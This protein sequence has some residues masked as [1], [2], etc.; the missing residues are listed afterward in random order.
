MNSQFNI[1]CYIFTLIFRLSFPFHQRYYTHYHHYY[2]YYFCYG[3]QSDHCPTSFCPSHVP[4][5]SV[6]GLISS[7]HPVFC[8]PSFL[9]TSLGCHA[10]QYTGPNPPSVLF[11]N[12]NSPSV[13]GK[14]TRYHFR[15]TDR[16]TTQKYEGTHTNT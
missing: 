8:L 11:S 3:I 12:S 7:L 1:A 4:S 16:Q 14:T 5:A 13:T 10:E 2:Y 15:G 9:V 6:N